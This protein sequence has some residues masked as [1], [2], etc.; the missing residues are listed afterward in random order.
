MFGDEEEKRARERY[1]R[2]KERFGREKR[3][4]V[5][6]KGATWSQTKASGNFSNGGRALEF[7]VL[8]FFPDFSN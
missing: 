5:V 7:R 4:K 2:W 8:F 6:E 1:R 3:G